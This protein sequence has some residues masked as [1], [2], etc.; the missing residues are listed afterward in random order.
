MTTMP[1]INLDGTAP[2]V[3]LE[4]QMDAMRAL[5]IALIKLR[6]AEPNAR[7]YQTAAPAFSRAQA[8]RVARLTFSRAQAEHVAR[9]KHLETVMRE[10]DEIAQHLI[11]GVANRAG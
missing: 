7:D 5:R 9:L 2:C 3:L 8:Q 11:N 1:T 4:Q 6:E 10:L